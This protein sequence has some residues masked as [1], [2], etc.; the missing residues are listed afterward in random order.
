YNVSNNIYEKFILIS[1]IIS[2]ILFIISAILSM[3]IYEKKES[4]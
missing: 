3:R 4:M 1:T 2:I